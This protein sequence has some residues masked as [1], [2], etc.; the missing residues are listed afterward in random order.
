LLRKGYSDERVLAGALA[1]DGTSDPKRLTRLALRPNEKRIALAALGVR[2][3]ADRDAYFALARRLCY[4]RDFPI[5]FL[6]KF[7]GEPADVE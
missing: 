2:H 4:D 5:L 6:R 1:P 3:A 7:L